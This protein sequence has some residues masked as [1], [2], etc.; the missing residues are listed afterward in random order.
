MASKSDILEA[1]SI[2]GESAP[3]LIEL[4]LKDLDNIF[5]SLKE[6]IRSSD[7]DGLSIS[8]HSLKSVLSQVGA[9]DAA[10]FAFQLEKI[11][12]ANDLENASE[13]LQ[14]LEVELNEVKIV[15]ES[16]K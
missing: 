11:G 2:Y 12:K 4:T 16:L 9:K 5:S 1:I 15:F 13:F 3:K 7:A 8:A 10:G 14:K 6:S